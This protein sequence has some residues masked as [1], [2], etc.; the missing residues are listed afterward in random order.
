MDKLACGVDC[1]RHPFLGNI[2]TQNGGTAG[3]Q[4]R[5][6]L[7]SLWRATDEK[8]A[9]RQH[10][11]TETEYRDLLRQLAEWE[12]SNSVVMPPANLGFGH[13]PPPAKPNADNTAPASFEQLQAR[14]KA[15]RDVTAALVGALTYA[16][17]TATKH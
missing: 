4:A 11:L 10:D 12:K 14:T 3:Q 6:Y 13:R 16:D 2:L 17:L 9:G 8:H 15:A 7:Y 5:N 1:A